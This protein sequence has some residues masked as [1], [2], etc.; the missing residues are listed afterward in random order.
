MATALVRSVGRFLIELVAG[1]TTT[2]PSA[3]RATEEKPPAPAETAKPFVNPDGT[4]VW[5]NWL[6]PHI[7][8][9]PYGR[10]ARLWEKPAATAT[11]LVNQVG[12]AEFPQHS[13]PH[14]AKL[15]SATPP[16][17]VPRHH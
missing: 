2:R 11:A 17:R 14:S 16:Q 10:N 4:S 9:V 13:S 7:T 1:H 6:S 5:P 8:T 12:T 3:T 15:R